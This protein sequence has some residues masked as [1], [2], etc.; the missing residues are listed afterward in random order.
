M[1]QIINKLKDE[2][3][4]VYEGFEDPLELLA[5]F[6]R[7]EKTI[8][9][10]KDVIM[11]TALLELERYGNKRETETA[12]FEFTQSGRYDYS[13]NPDYVKLK[14]QIKEIESNMKLSYKKEGYIDPETGEFVEPAEYKA[15]SPAIR[16]K[17]K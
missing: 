9:E 14:K 15:N 2:T 12:V 1:E 8:S 17:L 7:I 11:E 4:Q 16:I 5:N 10:C 6:K 13:R 3:E